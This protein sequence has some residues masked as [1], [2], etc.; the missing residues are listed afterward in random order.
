MTL[1]IDLG[2]TRA[3]LTIFDAQATIVEHRSVAHHNLVEQL[4]Q[5]LSVR[6]E[7]RRICWCAVG[8]IQAEFPAFLKTAAARCNNSVLRPFPRASPSV[9]AHQQPS[10][11]TVWQP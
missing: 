1:T 9:I 8:D 7:I 4:H 6:P 10:V 11:L 3:K 5:L 2:N